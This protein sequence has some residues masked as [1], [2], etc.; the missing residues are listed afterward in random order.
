M[1][2]L[3]YL[4]GRRIAAALG[5]LALLAACADREDESFAGAEQRSLHEWIRLHRPD[6]V[7]NYQSDGG[8]YVDIHAVGSA[9]E[10]PIG[11][12]VCWVR[13]DFTGRDLAGNICLTRNETDA[14]QLGSFTRYTHYVPFFKFSGETSG[15]LLDGVNLALRNELTLGD[16]YASEHDYPRTLNAR[17]GTEMTVYMPST[18]I[19][20]GGVGGTGGYE[21]QEFGKTT[22][23]LGDNR[24]MIV[25]LKVTQRVGNPIAYEGTEVDEFAKEN[26]G[27]LPPKT[28]VDTKAF[29]G[30]DETQY[31]DGFSW[32]SPSWN[33]Q[34]DSI[35]QLYISHTYAPSLKSDSMLRY[36]NP[37]RSSVAPYDDMA[38]L[39]LRINQALIDR[40]GYG[41]LEAKD[42]VG[43]EGS[44][45]V[46]YIGRFMDGFI[47]DTNIDEVKEIIYGKV[48]TKSSAISYTPKTNKE[49]YVMGWYYTIP[50]LRYGQ[51]AAIEGTSSYFYGATGKEGT[52]TTT[53]SGG[54]TSVDY[55]D[56][57]N[58]YNYMNSYYGYGY[59]GG[60]YD[61]Y[62]NG[63]YDGLY[64][65]Y[66]QTDQSNVVKT[67]KVTTEVQA[68]TP[69]IFQL[70]IEPQ[71]K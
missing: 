57:L 18:V 9:D 39:E 67:S 33:S 43:L 20:A 13:F 35:P 29:G 44:A 7:E 58:Y 60:Y 64:S 66:D 16:E 65:G 52:T 6:L 32:R 34:K 17:E 21:G 38:A 37:Y 61:G 30:R 46:W 15:A 47:F 8:Y 71:K 28:P 42:T 45:I 3:T 48:E 70:Y 27:L 62:Y 63:Y 55:N 10:K 11:D 68:Y 40:F 49:S 36:R 51:W 53:S 25:R 69:L 12:S 26:G 59:M 4:F 14:R 31:N 54:N 2:R 50:H 24:P 23:T 19:G 56:M 1:N 22:Y 41:T 5:C